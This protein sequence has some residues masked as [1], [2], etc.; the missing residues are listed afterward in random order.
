MTSGQIAH[1]CRIG[2]QTV[3]A[4][5]SLLAGY[6]EIEDQAFIS[7]NVVVHQHSKIGRLAMVGGGTRVNLDV[8]PYFLYSDFNVRPTGLNSVGLRPGGL[9]S[10]RNSAPHDGSHVLFPSCFY[11]DDVLRIL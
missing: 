1:N 5:C 7:G 2:N 11:V 6:V 4:S 3:I 8:P 9:E 10:P